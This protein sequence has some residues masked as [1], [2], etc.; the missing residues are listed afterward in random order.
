METS[1]KTENDR[2]TSPESVPIHF[3]PLVLASHKNYLYET[4]LNEV[5]QHISEKI[6]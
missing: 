5:P 3:K 6:S 4:S 2:V 1:N